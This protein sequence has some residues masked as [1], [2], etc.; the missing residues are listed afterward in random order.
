MGNKYELTNETIDI[1]GH[2]LYRIRALRSFGDVKSGALG[3][4][5]ESEANLSHIGGCWVYEDARIYGRAR[6]Y[7]T[8]RIREN[9]CVFGWARVYDDAQIYGR[10]QVFGEAQV[11]EDAEVYGDAKVFGEAEVFG[12]AQIG[13]NTLMCGCVG[14]FGKIKLDS[15]IWITTIKIDVPWYLLST[16]LQK[17]V[18][19]E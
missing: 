19:E 16:T 11:Y 5:I 14:V 15:G 12:E 10:A 6:V 4:F 3:G 17:I 18:L 13:G 9:A 1:S 7:D 8:V 2:I